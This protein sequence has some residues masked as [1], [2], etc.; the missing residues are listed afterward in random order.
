[1]PENQ[2]LPELLAD[3][4]TSS[5]V[6][7]REVTLPLART[8]TRYDSQQYKIRSTAAHTTTAAPLDIA[9]N[10]DTIQVG[11]EGCQ[12]TADETLGGGGGRSI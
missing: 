10:E 4:L 6:E 11:C 2:V 3:F 7:V 1:M 5:V 12:R 8:I 9:E